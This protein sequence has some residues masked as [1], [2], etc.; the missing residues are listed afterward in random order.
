VNAA[1]IL[2][3]HAVSHEWPSEF[4]VTPATLKEQIEALLRRGYQGMT[5]GDAAGAPAGTKAVAVTFDDGFGSVFERAFP[6]LSELGVPATV[7]VVT[8]FIGAEAPLAWGGMKDWLEGRSQ[9][10][11]KPMS[12]E[13]LEQLAGAGWEI[14]SHTRSHPALTG[15]DDSALH[16]ELQ[17]SRELLE[18]RLGRRCRSFAYPFGDFDDR[19]VAAVRAAG[20]EAAA[21]FGGRVYLEDPL[22]WPRVVVLRSDSSARFRLKAS[23]LIRRLRAAS[24]R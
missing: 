16:E 22:R 5:F 19:V 7:F 3:Y 12:W 17:G 9:A 2:A 10:E 11:L 6:V 18:Q 1:V 23:P 24:G 21:T 20:Y 8:D 4:A 13:Q 15:L 14:G